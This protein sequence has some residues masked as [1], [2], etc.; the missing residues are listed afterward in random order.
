VCDPTPASLAAALARLAD[1]AGLA[2]RL[3]IR[4]AAR[5]AEMTWPA[6]VKRL[7]IV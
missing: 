1:D 4:A 7:V 6:A 5:A 2:E 3:G